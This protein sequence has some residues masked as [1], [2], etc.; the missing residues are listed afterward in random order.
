[1]LNNS[2]QKNILKNKIEINKLK[3]LPKTTGVYI[4]RAANNLPLYI[5]KS[6]NI[7]SRV[8]SHLRNADEHKMISQTVQ[9]DFIETAGEIGALLLESK[10][11]KE[12]SPLFNMR[13][14]R[15]RT[16]C[17]IAIKKTK[18]GIVPVIVHDKSVILGKTPNLYGLFPSKYAANGRLKKL[19]QK[20]QLCQ[21]ILNLEKMSNRG[22]FGLQ[23]KTCLGACVGKENRTIH[24]NRLIN[25]LDNFRVEIW[26]FNGPIDLIEKSDDWVQRH[27]IMNWCYLGTWCS[28]NK[29]KIQANT[30]RKFDLDYY[31]IL[32]KPI[33]L[34]Q[35]KIELIYK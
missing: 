24:D 6:I 2:P 8:M 19:A 5:G 29:A 18:N 28:K 33:M 32:V 22:C 10:M 16:L 13:L 3:N 7:R 4:L 23:L 31:K 26:P 34:N 12:Q 27:R 11:I 14:R 9:V 17:S 25:A 20:H 35:K 1:M 21:A 15:L 30:I